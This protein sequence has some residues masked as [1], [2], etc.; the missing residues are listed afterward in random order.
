MKKSRFKTGDFITAPWMTRGVILKTEWRDGWEQ[1]PGEFV[2]GHWAYHIARVDGAVKREDGAWYSVESGNQRVGR[3]YN[4]SAEMKK[5]RA[6]TKPRTKKSRK[7]KGLARL[8]GNIYADKR[9][10]NPA[11][12]KAPVFIVAAIEKA[13]GKTVYIY[14][15]P[16][17]NYASTAEF[18]DNIEHA[19]RFVDYPV[20]ERI[21]AVI[22]GDA[23]LP[24]AEIRNGRVIEEKV[25]GKTGKR[26]GN[27]RGIPK[28]SDPAKVRE[29]G[30]YVRALKGT[31]PAAKGIE[32]KR[33]KTPAGRH[34]YA[35]YVDGK[36]FSNWIWD[37]E[38]M[39]TGVSI[40][41]AEA[42]ARNGP[43]RANNPATVATR[44][45]G[46][47]PVVLLLKGHKM[48]NAWWTGEV[49]DSD[50]KKA[51][52]ITGTILADVVKLAQKLANRMPVKYRIEVHPAKK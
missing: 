13:T 2:P 36:K 51:R 50:R 38:K 28:K 7:P 14:S 40:T 45:K 27:P 16:D 12:K 47:E 11:P 15:F 8:G 23:Q 31:A 4:E 41:D 3:W 48:G 10:D 21:S 35:V 26:K 39:A 18:G 46:I 6:P 44:N 9:A 24:D 32:V 29:A 19:R 30:E 42:I 34:Q 22:N 17:R 49:W 37:D 52:V 43:W 25:G 5:A 1:S 20:A 33:R